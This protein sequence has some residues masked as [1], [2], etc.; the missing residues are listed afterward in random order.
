MIIQNP[1]DSL[2]VFEEILFQKR[3]D[4]LTENKSQF[5]NG[6]VVFQRHEIG[7]TQ[8]MVTVQQHFDALV[9]FA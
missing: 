6:I 4:L 9:H 3:H 8:T 2:P 7:M 1:M 5:F